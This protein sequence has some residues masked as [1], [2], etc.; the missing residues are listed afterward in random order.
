MREK[1]LNFAVSEA[2]LLEHAERNV[3]DE[4]VDKGRSLLM[5]TTL[6]HQV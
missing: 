3:V 1:Q 2:L 5:G 6:L 4:S